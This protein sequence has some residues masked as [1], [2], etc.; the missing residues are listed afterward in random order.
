MD[1]I[2][3]DNL[4]RVAASISRELGA[5]AEPYTR[6]AD[7]VLRGNVGCYFISQEFRAYELHR[8]NNERGGISR[9]AR[10]RTKA[11]LYDLAHALWDGI[12]LGLE[13]GSANNGQT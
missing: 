13:K 5:P 9:V 2:N 7:G 12:R 1:R 11:E 8:M 10:G 6:G 4:K 3:L